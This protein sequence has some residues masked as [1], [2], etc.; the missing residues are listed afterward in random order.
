MGTTNYSIDLNGKEVDWK[1]VNEDMAHIK[2]LGGNADPELIYNS[3]L[4]FK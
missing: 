2:V 3:G 1:E 4:F